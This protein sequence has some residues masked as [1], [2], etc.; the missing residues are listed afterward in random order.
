MR[1]KNLRMDII[2]N[3][4]ILMNG[5]N[6]VNNSEISESFLITFYFTTTTNNVLYTNLQKQH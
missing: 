4:A 3:G 2:H 1:E 5:N 6:I